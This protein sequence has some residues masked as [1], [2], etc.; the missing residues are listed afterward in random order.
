[1]Q[2]ESVGKAARAVVLRLL[3]GTRWDVRHHGATKESATREHP[4]K[5]AQ[6]THVANTGN[7][8]MVV[9]EHGAMVSE[10]THSAN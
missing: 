4:T 3:D 10:E 9:M 8:K 7:L 1:M 2:L 5:I 6:G